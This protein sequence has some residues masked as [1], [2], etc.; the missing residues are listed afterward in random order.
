MRDSPAQ[1]RSATPATGGVPEWP[2]YLALVPLVVGL[3]GILF[4]AQA[5]GELAQRLSIAWGAVLLAFA[6]AVHFG[7]AL[8]A[9][10][11][12]RVRTWCGALLT[13]PLA[14]GAVL[15]G[16][17]RALALLVVGS[18]G[19][20]LYEHR[21]LGAL[22]PPGYLALRRVQSV[23]ACALLT[24]AMFASERAGL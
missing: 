9:R 8:A 23:G 14:A 3:A 6:G 24:L 15:L 5:V 1:G 18:G 7:L 19:L 2:V 13:A 22:L 10:L 20:W 16:G 21:V 17:Q 4:G 11:P 12:W